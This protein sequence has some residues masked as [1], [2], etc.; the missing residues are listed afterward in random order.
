MSKIASPSREQK[1]YFDDQSVT[2]GFSG[3]V[4]KRYSDFRAMFTDEFRDWLFS[5]QGKEC[6]YCGEFL[7]DDW[8]G[9]GNAHVEHVKP[10][11]DDG[12]DLPPNLAFAC[13]SCNSQKGAAHYSEL[14]I[15]IPMRKAGINGI[16]N[17]D[18][19]AQL[20]EKGALSIT[21]LAELHFEKKAWPHIRQ[22]AD[23]K[24]SQELRKRADRIETAAEKGEAV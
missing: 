8:S 1:I 15:K 20:I 7:G 17:H 21:P 18:Q 11:S 3:Y 6:A 19:A 12:E 13:R 14:K 4:L 5:F 23:S 24:E 16:I 10:R 9:N 2:P 22:F